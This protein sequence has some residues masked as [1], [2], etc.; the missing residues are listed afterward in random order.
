MVSWKLA[1]AE[2]RA[3]PMYVGNS[4]ADLGAKTEG[5]ALDIP[6]EADQGQ[7]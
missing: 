7:V 3:I 1:W 4:S 5:Q 6:P 2:D